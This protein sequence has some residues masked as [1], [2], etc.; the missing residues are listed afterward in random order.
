MS[1]LNERERETYYAKFNERA[2]LRGS[3]K[4][5]GEYIAKLLGSGGSAQVIEQNEA[6]GLIEFPPHKDGSGLSS[7][8]GV[9]SNES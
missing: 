8:M 5:Q 2:L 4:D 6:R 9:S 7:G 3:M 1:L